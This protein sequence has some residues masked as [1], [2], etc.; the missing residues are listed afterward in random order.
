LVDPW[1]V[2]ESKKLV[3]E[4][5]MDLSNDHCPDCGAGNVNVA[6]RVKQSIGLEYYTKCSN[7]GRE[8]VY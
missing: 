5:M 4:T 6:F 1:K 7:C 3:M 2:K 8:M